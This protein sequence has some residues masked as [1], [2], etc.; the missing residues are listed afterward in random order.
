MLRPPYSNHKAALLWRL[1]AGAISRTQS[2]ACRL[3]GMGSSL[4]AGFKRSRYGV[5]RFSVL[6]IAIMVLCRY[7]VLWT[8]SI[9]SHHR[10][11]STLNIRPFGGGGF[12]GT[13][14]CRSLHTLQGCSNSVQHVRCQP[15]LAVGGAML[16][17][18]KVS[19]QLP[20]LK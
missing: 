11:I 19:T 8:L 18:S 2:L 7:L 10:Q 13:C 12:E 15:S 5:F 20:V 14:R 6:G 9:G 3:A 4:L 17:L 1:E 16:Q